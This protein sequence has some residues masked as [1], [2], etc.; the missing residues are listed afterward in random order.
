[1]HNN[2]KN[3]NTTANK[4]NVLS[5]NERKFK[6][7]LSK[8]VTIKFESPISKPDKPTDPNKSTNTTGT[9]PTDTNTTDPHTNNVKTAEESKDK[10]QEFEKLSMGKSL[11][12]LINSAIL[13]SSNA[14]N[15]IIIWLSKAI[16]YH[17]VWF[18]GILAFYIL[19]FA[20]FTISNSTTRQPIS[21]NW[22]SII[23]IIFSS[24]FGVISAVY[25]LILIPTIFVYIFYLAK[26]TM[27]ID[28]FFS[29][30]G[31]IFL[32][33]SVLALFPILNMF[34]FFKIK[35]GA[36]NRRRSGG[37]SGSRGN[38]YGGNTNRN[39][40]RNNSVTQPTQ[41][42]C[43]SPSTSNSTYGGS[44]GGSST[45]GGSTGSS[46]PGGPPTANNSG[47]YLLYFISFIAVSIPS[48]TCAS[49]I[50]SSFMAGPNDNTKY[51]KGAILG[52]GLMITITL[53]FLQIFTPHINSLYNV[54]NKIFK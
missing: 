39:R 32:I 13:I 53:I 36:R 2:S 3:E 35:E 47:A 21:T 5:I 7:E 41:Q 37:R 18:A 50:F 38:T 23:K 1:M 29:I 6:N 49:Q 40:R 15:H 11:S 22:V 17:G 54:I 48:V 16:H 42:Q 26:V 9:K 34:N 25:T 51:E 14:S 30:F 43:S 19:I 4:D 24:F 27:K 46:Q 45:G 8:L 33:I 44:A 12:Y 28:H 31:F 52:F 20:M 10:C